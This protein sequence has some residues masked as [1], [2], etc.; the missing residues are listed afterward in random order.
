MK[1]FYHFLSSKLSLSLIAMAFGFAFASDA[2]A[3]TLPTQ[4]S[5]LFS[6]SGNCASCHEPGFP[7][8]TA[9]KDAA[10][11]DISPVTLW[12]STMM[13]NAFR[14]PL[15][16][17][18]VSAEIVANPHLQSVIED[19]CTTCHAPLGRTEAIFNGSSGY[20]IEE[21][22][23]DPLARD[24]VSC[25][26]CHQIKDVNLGTPESFSGHYIVEN[27]RLIYGPF[28]NLTVG[29]MQQSVNYTPVFGEQ[30]HSSTLCATCHTLFTPYV[31]ND[32]NIAG[33]APEQVPYLEWK[34]SVY[35]EQNI[36][37]QTCHMP[38]SEEAIVISNRPRS[39][40]ARSPFAKHYFVGA[41]VFMLRILKEHGAEL[42]VTATAAQFDSTIA[43]TLNILQNQTIDLGAE[44][45]WLNDSLEIQLRVIN[46]TGHKFPTAYPSRRA[47][48]QLQVLND[49]GQ[50]VFASGTW[51]AQTGEI[52]GLDDPY[53]PHHDVITAPGQVQVYQTIMK[54]ID[55]KVNYTLLRAA[56]F[57]K[58]NRLPPE[59][60]TSTG[61]DYEHTAIE[62]LALDDAS[63]NR[64]ASG[65]GTGADRIAYRIGGL[66]QQGDYTVKVELL[67]QT[68][69]P[70]FLADLFQYDTPEV[71]TFKG[72]YEQADKS[73]VLIKAMQFTVTTTGIEQKNP[74]GPESYLLLSVYP[75]PFN[76]STS[77]EIETRESGDIELAIFDA[78]GNRVHSMRS[79]GVGAG[80]HR[81]RWNA[82]DASGNP[83]ASGVYFVSATFSSRQSGI[84]RVQT[85]K[86][87]YLK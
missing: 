38:H 39:L 2:A 31:D 50:T 14:D 57:L 28:Q 25:T 56:G 41:N 79:S 58:D 82:S 7:N 67:Y 52:D 18:K 65:E 44:G 23:S 86:I 33:E 54:D 49:A 37:C 63:F 20:T 75:N 59:G 19:K 66:P 36:E 29:P 1:S 53:E 16:R 84:T 5:T 21:G 70:R 9:L 61:P 73:P 74:A 81:F 6:G 45:A 47:W 22:T 3:Q 85:Q 42:G 69:P 71:Q 72:Y 68:A 76:P 78:R 62:G 46:K 40:G 64:D 34:N 60:F 83:V 11:N 32:G 55:G 43:R 24:G 77:I 27:D 17:A 8:T 15:W 10:G 26:L 4:T 30:T 80:V 13:A 87:L 35:P 12:R 48:V 51:D